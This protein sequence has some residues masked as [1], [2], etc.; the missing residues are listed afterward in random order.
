LNAKT[1]KEFHFSDKDFEYIRAKVYALA[2]IALSDYKREMVYSRL[3]RRL[4]ALGLKDFASYCQLLENEQ[5]DELGNFINSLTTNLTRFFRE[6]HHF[7]YLKDHFLPEL[8]KNDRGRRRLRIWSA[9][10][11]TGA[12]PYSIAMTVL[13]GLPRGWD[14]KLLATDLDTNVLEQARQGELNES[15]LNEIPKPYC[16]S[17]VERQSNVAASNAWRMNATV[18]SPIFFKQLNLMNTWPMKGPFQVIFCRNVVIYFDKPTQQRLF[19][20]YYN[21]LAPGGLLIL[22]HSESLGA[23]AKRFS[24][25]ERTAYQ[26]V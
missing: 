12:E 20:R 9:G 18:K 26:K 11:S 2:G 7:D 6:K 23:M 8:Y 5:H 25:V 4:R 14:F 16:Q 24:A 13:S 3:A 10:C 21:L 1:G 19:E 17:F 22:G 15:M